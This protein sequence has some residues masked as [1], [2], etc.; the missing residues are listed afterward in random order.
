MC[1]HEK[2]RNVSTALANFHLG[3][4]NYLSECVI[5]FREIKLVVLL[6]FTF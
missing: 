2:F 3:N 6:H 5:V 1:N 4:F